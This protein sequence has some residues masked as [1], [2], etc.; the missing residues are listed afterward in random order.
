MKKSLVTLLLC[1]ACNPV[2]QSAPPPKPS[3]IV[4][5]QLIDRT[6]SIATPSWGESIRWR[7]STPI[8]V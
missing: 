2:N 4:V 7:S 8:R 1:A 5:G 6:G 3:V